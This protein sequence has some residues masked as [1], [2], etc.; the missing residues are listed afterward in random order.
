MFATSSSASSRPSFS[1]LSTLI[2]P[3]AIV[4]AVAITTGCGSGGTSSGGPKLT[5]NTSVTLVV[6][7]TANNELS[8]FGIG[9]TGITL[10]NQ[11]GKT[12]TLFA[13]PQGT[14]QVSEFIHVNGGADPLLTVSVPQDVY[15]AATVDVGR[16]YF[17]CVTRVPAGGI[18][19]H[20]FGYGTTSDNAPQTNVTVD[21]PSP[22]TISGDSMGLSLDLQVAQSATY[23]SCYDPNGQ[24]TFSIQPTF[25]LSPLTFSSQPTNPRNGKVRQ[26]GGQIGAIGT[27]GNSLT[28]ALPE[29]PRN[30]SINANGNTVYQGVGSFSGLAVGMFLDMDVAIQRDGSLL[31][32]RIAV[33]DPVAVDMLK[34]SVLFVS[35][36]QP[37]IPEPSA[38]FFNQASQGAEPIPLAWPYG[39]ASSLFQISGEIHNLQS[40]P[41]VAAFDGSN[42]VAGQQVFVSSQSTQIN[43]GVDP[44]ATTITLMPQT[45]NGTVVASAASGNFTDYTVSLASY[46]LFPT[47]AVQPGQTTLLANPSQVEVYVDSNTQKINTQPLAPGNTLRFYGLVFNDNGTLRMDCA[48]VNDGVTASSQPAAGARFEAG[49]TRTVT[50]EGPGKQSLTTTVVT[51]SR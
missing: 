16:S 23:S 13:T 32:S 47:L 19:I 15:T 4:V 7:S 49:Q 40:L 18:E 45:I 27:S 10:T 11:S 29:G 17:A 26:L 2:V 41:F 5:G 24:Y 6:S 30:L 25:A 37:A 8:R 50:R 31:A 33:A 44:V 35:P 42:M 14:D 36:Y 51:R 28:L 9:L 39:T 38:E 20:F 21:L 48:Q 3:I 12:V 34:G 1:Y 43:A 46:N 22:I